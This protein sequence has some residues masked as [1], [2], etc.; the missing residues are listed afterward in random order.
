MR[1]LMTERARGWFG[2]DRRVQARE[3]GEED[4]L[5]PALMEAL[6]MQRLMPATEFKKWF[7]D[8]LPDL[9]SG[10]VGDVLQAAAR[11]HLAAAIDTV[12]GDY[13]GEHWLAT[14]AAL[15]LTGTE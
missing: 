13:M 5:S 11:T 6:A 1:K 15:A 9:A 10:A 2:M 3:L 14:F 7:S 12:T 8:F 4:F